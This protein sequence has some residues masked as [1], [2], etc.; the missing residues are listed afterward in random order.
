M[1]SI[2]I[3][4]GSGKRIGGPFIQLPKSMIRVNDKTIIEYQISVLKKFGIDEIIV[5]TGPYSEK[6]TIDNL[7]YVNDKNFAKHD[8]LGS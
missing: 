2:I 8:I 4:A 1:K 5:I 7:N 6:F 3:A